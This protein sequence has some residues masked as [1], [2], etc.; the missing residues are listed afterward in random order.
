MDLKKI[1]L[2]CMK[3]FFYV[4]NIKIETKPINTKSITYFFLISMFIALCKM[5]YFDTR[6]QLI[7]AYFP[8]QAKQESRKKPMFY[9]LED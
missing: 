7:H 5:L 4:H 2:Y 8:K 6:G 3:M 9:I 1:T